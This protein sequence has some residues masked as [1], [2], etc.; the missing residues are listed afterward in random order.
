MLSD[1]LATF[2]A[3]L[4]QRRLDIIAE[5]AKVSEPYRLRVAEVEHALN[6]LDGMDVQPEIDGTCRTANEDED[7][8]VG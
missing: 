8:G 3:M 2:R 6:L 1:D 5:H 7:R 4:E